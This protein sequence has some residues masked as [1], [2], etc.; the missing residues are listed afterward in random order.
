MP[1]MNFSVKHNRTLDDAKARMASAIDQIR[2]QYG[3]LIQ[4]VDWSPDRDH[5]TLTATGAVADLRVDAQ[6]VHA[7]VDIPLLSALLGGQI[8]DRLKEVVQ[9]QLEAPADGN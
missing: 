3:P 4:R 8:A 7:T 5:V 2:R 1:L 9:K 6:D